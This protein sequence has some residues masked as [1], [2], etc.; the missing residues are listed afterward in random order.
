M[1]RFV[2]SGG[3]QGSGNIYVRSVT[4]NEAGDHAQA[5]CVLYE[6]MNRIVVIHPEWHYFDDDWWQVDD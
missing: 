6:S 2:S 4:L 5:E 1:E 3:L